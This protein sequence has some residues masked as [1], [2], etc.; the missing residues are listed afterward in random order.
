MPM[1]IIAHR[2]A[3]QEAPENTIPAVILAWQE[4]ADGL[5][6]DV[7]MTADGKV[8]L[9][10][11]ESTARTTR[12]NLAVAD[13]MWDAIRLLDA[14]SWKS[15]RYRM[16][17][18]PLLR[19]ILKMLPSGREIWIEIKCGA[20]II[21]ALQ[22]DL[23]VQRL[24]PSSVGFLGFSAHLMGQV[25]NAFPKHPVYLNVEA[26]GKAGAP[27]PWTADRLVEQVRAYMLDGLSVGLS[28][29]VDE[30]FINRIRSEGL[31]LM[32]WVADDE[33]VALRLARAGIP[34]LMTNRPAYIRHRLRAHGAL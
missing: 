33:H 15:P 29:A 16:T 34:A 8:V 4:K 17:T 19:D 5:E 9:L 22:R 7:R 28:D 20:E 26:R 10:H 1:K 32:G 18:I 23:D 27:Q 2:G 31:G 14:G 21:P 3:S 30:V 11:D 12:Q 13:Q 25:K 24:P 6:V